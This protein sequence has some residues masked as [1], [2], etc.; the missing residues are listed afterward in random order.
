[1]LDDQ[2][3]ASL[4]LAHIAYERNGLAQAEQFAARALDLAGQRGNEM[5]QVQATIR[6]AHIRAAR[7]DLPRAIEL[8]KPLVTDIQNPILLREIQEAQAHLSIL[9]GDLSAL[10]GW[11]SL[12]S[13]DKESKLNAQK[14]RETFTLARL[15]IAE[16]KTIEAL[17]MLQDRAAD[18][19]ENGRV[20]SQVTALC[21]EALAHYADSNL[22]QAAKSLTEALTMA[23]AKGFRRVFLDEGTR[24]TALLQAILPTLPRRT[25]S[26]YAMNLLH[27]FDSEWVARQGAWALVEPLSQQELRV[28]RLLVAG[29][30]NTDIAQELIVSINTV[31]T[32]VKSIYRK[33]DINSRDEARQVARELK[34]F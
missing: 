28:L 31:K 20:K 15:R 3:F 19:A 23:Q 30:S 9:A 27:S 12:I 24:M 16:G 1:M 34:L 10:T 18:A 22:S 2:G 14:E 5:L 8:L 11:Q 6:Q 29:Q 32:H 4:S 17:E 21:L 13:D 25:Q 33:L 26:L 7:N